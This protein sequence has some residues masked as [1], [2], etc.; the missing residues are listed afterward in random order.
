MP[1]SSKVGLL[2]PAGRLTDRVAAV[3]C[4]PTTFA[5]ILSTLL[6]ESRSACIS[7]PGGPRRFCGGLRLKVQTVCFAAPQYRWWFSDWV[8]HAQ[9]SA[10][11]GPC[12]SLA[13][14]CLMFWTGARDSNG[15]AGATDALASVVLASLPSSS[16]ASRGP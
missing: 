9:Y 4:A 3:D 10:I 2:A 12:S 8:F 14:P 13:G 11:A 6:G 5:A 16:T 1:A 7:R 15:L